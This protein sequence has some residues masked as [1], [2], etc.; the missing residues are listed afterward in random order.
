MALCFCKM[1][2]LIKEVIPALEKSLASDTFPGY[3]QACCIKEKNFIHQAFQIFLEWS[4][5]RV[6]FISD[7][8]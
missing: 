6:W 2:F 4:L 7:F 1:N 3:L 8:T 5:R